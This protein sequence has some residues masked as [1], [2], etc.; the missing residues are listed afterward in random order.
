M[1]T[2]YLILLLM[3]NIGLF[4]QKGI[5]TN[6]P[7]E[8]AVLELS[9]TQ[10][11]FLPPRMTQAQMLNIANP[12][13][14]L[15]VYC[16]DCTPAAPHIYNGAEY[17]AFLLAGQQLTVTNCTGFSDAFPPGPTDATSID[18][19]VEVMNSGF[20][21]MN[22]TPN[23]SDLTLSGPGLGTVTVS[24]VSPSPVSLT[25][26]QSQVITY[27]FSGVA[28]TT[29]G[30]AVNGDW[31]RFGAVCSNT[32]QTV[33]P[34]ELTNANTY[35]LRTA[36]GSAQDALTDSGKTVDDLISAQDLDDIWNT[37]SSNTVNKIA[38]ILGVT[39]ISSV[40]L[41]VNVTARTNSTTAHRYVRLISDF[42]QVGGNAPV[43]LPLTQGSGAGWLL[44]FK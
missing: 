33:P 36:S 31:G 24:G 12:V 27:S 15:M 17:I 42:D 30:L 7:S 23:L 3:T 20:T 34:Y 22:F 28:S 16:T 13:P 40:T 10:K 39:N 9:S 6:N 35:Y 8:S 21:P 43:D 32:T 26:G 14:G 19:R 18:F 38:A 25:S 44:I 29:G 4:A 11:G 5:G 37:T 2:R 1:K 41:G